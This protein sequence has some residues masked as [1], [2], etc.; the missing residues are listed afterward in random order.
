MVIDGFCCYAIADCFSKAFYIRH[1]G[2]ALWLGFYTDNLHH[3][4]FTGVEFAFD[5][6]AVKFHT[7]IKV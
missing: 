3:G 4:I 5:D 7:V 1:R 2:S 6:V